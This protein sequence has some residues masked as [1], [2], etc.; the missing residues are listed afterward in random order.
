MD[1]DKKP[2]RN[3]AS[4]N[5]ETIR[6]EPDEAVEAD[7]DATIAISGRSVLASRDIDATVN[8]RE[9]SA[10]EATLWN[11]V[12]G[13]D[14]DSID[15]DKTVANPSRAASR[16]P[17][18]NPSVDSPAIDRTFSDRH[19]ERLRRNAVLEAHSDPNL[20]S[21]YRINR[22]LGQG[23]MGDVYLAR[24]RSL[25]R[26]LAL[27][28]IKPLDSKRRGQ[29][30]QAGRLESVEA[31]RQM[32]F[33]AEAII[34]GDL[35][36]P[37]IVPI[38]DVAVTEDG[39]LF[40]S[41]K[42]VDGT[43]WSERI[44]QLSQTENLDI[45]LR[46]CDAVGFA[47]TRNVVHRDIKPENIMLGDFGV[48][49]VMD[50]GL[51]LPTG[52]YDKEKQTSILL[53]SGLGGTPAFMAPEMATGPLDRIGPASDIYLLGATLFMIVTGNSPHF[54]RS[55]SECLKVVRSN[56]IREVDPKHR[57][58]LLDVAMHAMATDP[59]ERFQSVKEFQDAIRKF[60]AHDQS[61]GQ[62][63][64]AFDLLQ[65]GKQTRS[66]AIFHRA[67]QAFEEAIKSWSGNDRA[68]RGLAET[69]MTHAKIAYEVGELESG[70]ALLDENNPDHAEL[71][72][73][74]VRAR[75]ERESRVGR[76]RLLKRL[77]AALLVFILVGGGVALLL[78]NDQRNLA[79]ASKS[80]AER[81]AKKALKQSGI[82][83]EQAKNAELATLK[84]RAATELARKAADRERKAKDGE[85][86]AK[87]E[88][89][90]SEKSAKKNATAAK[91]AE[92]EAQ[93]A[94][95]RESI[96]RQN[97]DRQRE[98]ARYEEYVSKIGLAKARL[99]TND[100]KGA[101]KILEELKASPLSNGWEWRWLW[102]Q[103]NQSESDLQTDAAV[104]DLSVSTRGR[105]GVIVT[106]DSVVSLIQFDLA[107]KITGKQDIAPERVGG[108]QRPTS[109]AISPD[110]SQVAIGMK[111]GEIVVL[112]PQGDRV[113]RAHTRPVSDLQFSEEGQI[114]SGSL[115]RTVRVWNARTGREWTANQAL[116]HWSPVRQL[117]LS[118]ER[119]AA[120]DGSLRI[121]V[122]TA[123]Q[124]IGRVTCWS[125]AKSR[126][127]GHDSFEPTK[128]GVFAD[129][130]SP[131]SAVSITP[132]GRSVASGDARGNV[133]MW[134]WDALSPIDSGA[135]IAEAIKGVDR[136]VDE[137]S[138]TIPFV[139]FVD[140]SPNEFARLVSTSGTA[141][142][143]HA[144]GDAIRA[145]RFRGDGESL[146]TASD[147]YTVKLWDVQS[148]QM[149][150][151][152]RGH[153]GWVVAADF[154]GVKGDG[155]VSASNDASVRTWVA[156]NARGEFIGQDIRLVTEAGDDETGSGPR[157]AEAHSQGIS[158][159]RFSP[160]GTMI[161]TA[162][163]DHTARILT[164]DPVTL[165]FKTSA[166]LT[167]DPMDPPN[168]TPAGETFDEGTS[169][170]AMSMAINQA[171][172]R[173]MIGSADATIRIWDIQ[174][175]VEVDQVRG[176]GLNS[177]FSLSRDGTLL[178]TGSSSPDAK[179]IL[180]SID[181]SGK[182]PP[183]V[184]SRFAGH[185]QAL[186]AMAI[187]DDGSRIFTG[188]RGGYALIW[189]IATGKPIGAP[190]EDVRGFRINDA[191]F[192]PD[193]KT[194][195][196]AADDEQLTQIDIET[197]R[198]VR[199]LDH[200]GFVTKFAIAGDGRS[201][202]TLSE[203]STETS[204]TTRA[205]YWNLAD[206]S[207]RLLSQ[208][209]DS[210][211]R[212]R[213]ENS[214]QRSRITSVRIDPAASVIA[215]CQANVDSSPGNVGNVVD[216]FDFSAIRRGIEIPKA[217]Q[218]F[219]IPG[220][221]EASEVGIPLDPSRL[222][223]MNQNAAFEW[224]LGTGRLVK[225]FRSHAEL[226]QACFS[227]DG[228]WVA[229]ASRS[230]KIWD[231][232]TGKAMGKLESP[233]IGPV[234]SVVLAPKPIAGQNDVF[235]T[236]GDDGM[237]RMWNWDSESR[238]IN[239][240]QTLGQ[241]S[242]SGIRRVA[243]SPDAKRLA[244]VGDGGHIAVWELGISEPTWT[245]DAPGMGDFVCVAFSDDS[246]VLATGSTDHL[247]RVW[248]SEK[249]AMG[250]KLE[251]RLG[252]QSFWMGM[253]TSCVT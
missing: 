116:W 52:D 53:T 248:R 156:A 1:K 143:S 35:D 198:R 117:A 57:G 2:S 251:D 38:H 22:K 37:N 241:K 185:E 88:A 219:E 208:V 32:Q 165:A 124:N 39:D 42:R 142:E 246:R 92:I 54:A 5:D 139:R 83:K 41:M 169:Y 16:K 79:I 110:E 176:T 229:T 155:V 18:T 40:Y 125:I 73:K 183:R 170:V 232:A 99:E 91:A 17:S 45:L 90:A 135:S 13:N 196:I 89:I 140:E 36:H 3:P 112:S 206:G 247:A 236:G 10:N 82:A 245:L 103:A 86:L 200:D 138:S 199:R 225:S 121:A 242:G 187:S 222:L 119:S 253:P 55:V 107:G 96:A 141:S 81:E 163:H 238:T 234:R 62:T 70:I 226:T 21:D 178:L 188:D 252:N 172:N 158:S 84:A 61:I 243:F 130:V 147:D 174:Q 136:E 237:T 12:V 164:I 56:A 48:V 207:S 189:D 75:D 179:A 201:A 148:H 101:R 149:R 49:M 151:S 182:K 98:S 162:S 29:L 203:L 74:L 59:S 77:T 68:R 184:K 191:Q 58:E 34:T 15:T 115:D 24:Q 146:L 250:S 209:T 227:G 97:A 106:S 223:T 126:D 25:D 249:R 67:S 14:G 128:V 210:P 105:T 166:T 7:V 114:V 224:D 161:V 235:A 118:G 180:W 4:A 8:P 214:R 152:L 240:L 197:R 211:D 157:D 167:S 102:Q 127:D 173:L 80:E 213:G 100:G 76:L 43:P 95:R 46:V 122:A 212:G 131:V 113:L 33:L 69:T 215:V 78:I 9:L 66:L 132:D 104:I 160:D 204:L 134:N 145:L 221:L 218:R 216:L 26:L 159:A 177:G 150:T 63:D 244:A 71:Y 108:G 168:K 87:N 123:D 230:V 233:H 23:G 231:A 85:T 153:G 220:G 217:R 109:V 186:T 6:I 228:R 192:S 120:S 133:W 31:E 154:L 19:L 30:L 50:W 193:G 64:R 93:D 194:V 137:A 11:T 27:K 195:F 60:I 47:H 171:G 28:V 181:P 72:E 190:I 65:Q 144:H 20:P 239:P 111:S 94:Q 44:H 51:A 202:V 129:H 175:G 205:T